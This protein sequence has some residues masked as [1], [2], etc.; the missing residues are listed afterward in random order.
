[1]WLVASDVQLPRSVSKG[2]PKSATYQRSGVAKGSRGRLTRSLSFVLTDS[3][4]TAQVAATR[5]CSKGFW[6]GGKINSTLHEASHPPPV[7]P[8]LGQKQGGLQCTPPRESLRPFENWRALKNPGPRE[9]NR[10]RRT[11][12]GLPHQTPLHPRPS[13]HSLNES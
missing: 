4:M 12:T 8:Q 6:G 1:M 3:S 11:F 9:E 7:P 5:T 2:I 10:K 13:A